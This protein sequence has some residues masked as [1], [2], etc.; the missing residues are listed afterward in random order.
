MLTVVSS[1]PA[2]HLIEYETRV[3]HE[4]FG[5]DKS[6]YQ[7]APSPEVDEAWADLYN[8]TAFI[9]SGYGDNVF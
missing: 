5:K 3:F 1:A 6:I 2:Q 8:C 4:G 7:Q 9:H